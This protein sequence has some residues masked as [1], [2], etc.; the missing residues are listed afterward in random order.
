MF[1][2]KLFF[3]EKSENDMVP[4]GDNGI[5]KFVYRIYIILKLRTIDFFFFFTNVNMNKF[6]KRVTVNIRSY[7]F[8]CVGSQL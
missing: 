5:N 2:V 4:L 6:Q 8:S 1:I 3:T 7:L